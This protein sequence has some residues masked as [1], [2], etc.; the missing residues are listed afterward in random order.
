MFISWSNASEFHCV[1]LQGPAT[2]Q[3]RD[4]DHL[5]RLSGR[6]FFARK[7]SPEA[8][9]AARLG[10]RAAFSRPYQETVRHVLAPWLAR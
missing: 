7:F 9:D 6:F 2:V 3:A 1:S 8:D 4:I 5:R 10:Y